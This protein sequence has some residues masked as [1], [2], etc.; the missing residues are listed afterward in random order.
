MDMAKP[1]RGGGRR[2]RLGAREGGGRG[3]GT[4]VGRGERARGREGPRER[5]DDWLNEI[6]SRAIIRS[7]LF[8]DS[9][10]GAERTCNAEAVPIKCDGRESAGLPTLSVKESV[11]LPALSNE[12]LSVYRQILYR[13]I[14]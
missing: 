8:Q 11:G 1:R 6:A 12:N 14:L 2:Q 3:R 10:S 13:H 7:S 4:F 9:T 5:V